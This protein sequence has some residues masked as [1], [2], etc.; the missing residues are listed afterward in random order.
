MKKFNSTGGFRKDTAKEMNAE[1]LNTDL[2]GMSLEETKESLED[3]ILF[4]EEYLERVKTEIVE[5]EKGE[6]IR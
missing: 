5:T 1:D 6:R 3:T 2:K 4:N